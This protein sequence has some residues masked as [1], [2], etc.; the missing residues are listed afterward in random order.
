[1]CTGTLEKAPLPGLCTTASPAA[2]ATSGHSPLHGSP[3]TSIRP[4]CGAPGTGSPMTGARR[5]LV[6]GQS[7]SAGSC[8]SRVWIT[9]MPAARA[10]ASTAAA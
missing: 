2:A 1:M 9:G 8:A 7:A 3:R 4:R 10:A 5:F 6:G